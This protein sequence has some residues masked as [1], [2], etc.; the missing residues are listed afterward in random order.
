MK[1]ICLLFNLLFFSSTLFAQDLEG[2]NSV[3]HMRGYLRKSLQMEE[4]L[5]SLTY[6]D[7]EGSPFMTKDF[8]LGKVFTKDGVF[9]KV[10]MKYDIYADA[11]LFDLNGSELYLEAT[12]YVTKVIVDNQIF[13]ISGLPNSKKKPGFVIQLDSNKVSLYAKKNIYFRSAEPAKAIEARPT[14]AAFLPRANKYFVRVGSGPLVL[15]EKIKDIYELFPAEE[16]SLK[17][18]IKTEDLSFKTE[19]DLVKI[20]RFVGNGI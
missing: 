17:K 18:Y 5:K 11:F 14:P 20:V 10:K 15:I 13:V 6:Q 19:A 9:D 16:D 2:I 1:Q 7:I 12:E 3:N 8:G 4:G